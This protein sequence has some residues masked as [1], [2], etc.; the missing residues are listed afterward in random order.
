[1]NRS[2]LFA[3]STLLFPAAVSVGFHDDLVLALLALP[4]AAWGGAHYVATLEVAGLGA[5]TASLLGAC[6]GSVASFAVIL[7]AEGG[8]CGSMH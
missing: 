5:R 1:M 6:F 8:C 4:V 3:L 2:A 7:L